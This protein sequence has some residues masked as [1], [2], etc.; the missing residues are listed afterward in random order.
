MNIL[1]FPRFLPVLLLKKHPFFACF[2]IKLSPFEEMA[3]AI[4]AMGKLENSVVMSV[5]NKTNNIG[6]QAL[7]YVQKMIFFGQ[8]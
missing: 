5:H 8:F 4:I 6:T 7:K 1:N 2:F 3:T